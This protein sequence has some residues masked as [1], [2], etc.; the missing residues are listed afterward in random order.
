MKNA[1]LLLLTFFFVQLAYSQCPIIP[2]PQEYSQIDVKIPLDDQLTLDSNSMSFSTWEYLKSNLKQQT[3]IELVHDAENPY[4]QFGESPRLQVQGGPIPISHH[5]QISFNSNERK[6]YFETEE[7]AFHAVNSMLQLI[8]KDGLKFYFQGSEVSDSPGFEWRGL[9]L[10]VSRHFYTVDEVKRF[11][12]LMALY[13]FNTFHWHLTDD[14]GWRIEIKKYPKLA[15]IGAFRDST[16]MG[17]YSDEPRVFDT[18]KYGGFYTQDQ[19]KEVIKYAADRFVNVVPEIELPGHSRAAL[20]AY[21]ELSCTG[22]QKGV[23]GTWGVFDDIYCAKQETI[24]FMKDVLAEVVELFPSQYIHVGG[25]EAPK[26]RWKKCPDCQKVIA[27]NDLHDEHEL[28]SYFIGQI[29]EFLTGKGKKLIGWDEILEGGLSPNAAVMSWRG[30]KGGIEAAKQKHEVVMTPTTY[31]Y[32]DYYQSGH[33]SEPI[34][35]GGFLPLEKVYRFNPVPK[36]LNED[37]QRYILGGQANLWT[38][39][40]ASME[41]LEYMTYPRALALAQTVWCRK[42]PSYDSFLSDFLT[43]QEDYLTRNK[44]NFARSIHQPIL[45]ITRKKNGINVHFKGVEENYHYTVSTK[46]IGGYSMNGGQAMG[47]EDTLFFERCYSGDKVK[48]IRT[49]VLDDS[50]GNSLVDRFLLHACLGAEIEMVTQPHPKYNNNGSLNLVD[51]VK[52]TQPWKGSQWL[53]FDTSYVEFI[54]DLGEVQD[55]NLVNLGFL[56]QNGSWIYLPKLATIQVSKKSKW[57]LRKKYKHG[58]ES[59][60]CNITVGKKG[61]YV[62]VSIRAMDLIPIGMDGGGNTPWTFIDEIMIN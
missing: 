4:V 36:E 52:G 40:I 62:R 44:V 11:I 19:I 53:G 54:V 38:E 3:G 28:Q 21:P 57:F 56:N 10:D 51:G 55:I 31:C 60:D 29:D 5:Y 46:E 17:H 9:H 59:E 14:Q 16:M 1:A 12:D 6:V 23:P 42:K 34:A 22:E 47:V 30:M 58:I 20:A 49:S 8:Q 15:D 45:E 33:P 39:Y 37:E 32:F 26:T 27:D 13:K 35:I 25:D 24:D 48:E 7:S 18:K 50:G 41:H 43:Y 61:R 2:R